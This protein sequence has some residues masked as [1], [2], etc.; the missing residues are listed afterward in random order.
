MPGR[1]F[2]YSQQYQ[3]A[4]VE[5]GDVTLKKDSNS[6]AAATLWL[7]SLSSVKSTR[8]PK[9]PDEARVEEL[10]KVMPLHRN[11]TLQFTGIPMYLITGIIFLIDTYCTFLMNL[12]S[13][14]SVV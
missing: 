3:S 11:R 7:K 14:F 1:R 2:T 6:T 12:A 5:Q 9:H 4:T 8:H 13:V 10:R